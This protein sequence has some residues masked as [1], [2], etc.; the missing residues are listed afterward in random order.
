MQT[1]R[2]TLIYGNCQVFSPDGELM[3]RCLE[4]RAKWYLKRNLATIVSEDPLNIQL[5]FTPKGNGDKEALLKVERENICVVCGA[6]DLTKLTRHHLIPYEYRKFFPDE[7]KNHN[8]VFIV[9]ICSACHTKYEQEFAAVLKQDYAVRYNAPLH[10]VRKTLRKVS[11]LV[12][13]LINNEKI[14]AEK[15]AVIRL[16]AFGLLEKTNLIKNPTDLNNKES[17]VNIFD[18]IKLEAESEVCKHGRIVMNQIK[19]LANLES[20]WVANFLETMKPA[21]MPASLVELFGKTITGQT[22]V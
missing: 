17:L 1:K 22:I 19:D 7:R 16:Q 6:K 3:F 4:K 5:N 11:S 12:N 10:S 14:P 2:T 13:C 15:L 18:Y 21:F 9:P 8:S 20:E